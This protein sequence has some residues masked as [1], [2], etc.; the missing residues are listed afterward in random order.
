MPKDLFDLI[1]LKLGQAHIKSNTIN[2]YSARGFMDWFN[3]LYEDPCMPS[4]LGICKA[5]IQHCVVD[6]RLQ[7]GALI[8]GNDY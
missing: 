5:Q 8:K 6:S 4:E 7:S 3:I 2:I 1:E